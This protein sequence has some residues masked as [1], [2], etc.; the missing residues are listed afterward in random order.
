MRRCQQEENKR[1]RPLGVKIKD[2]NKKEQNNR[3][4]G[5]KKKNT[6]ENIIS[7]IC[8]ATGIMKTR[9]RNTT[10]KR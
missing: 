3:A 2:Y 7:F 10:R 9:R 6:G 8:R 4:W 1:G 5:I